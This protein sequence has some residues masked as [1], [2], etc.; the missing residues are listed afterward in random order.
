MPKAH[1]SS[2]PSNEMLRQIQETLL[3]AVLLSQ[4]LPGNNEPLAF[5]DL[6]FILRQPAVIV[7]DENLMGPISV[8]DLTNPVRFLSLEAIRKEAH[9]QGDITY[10]HF[11]PPVQEGDEVVITLEA[12]IAPH[13]PSQQTLGLSSVRIKFKQINDQ[14][15]AVEPPTF[16]AV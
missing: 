16:F 12:Q 5:P 7:L 14:W 13:N 1:S 11:Q 4:P 2:Q 10:L 9:T 8:A 6:P 15:V 3:Q